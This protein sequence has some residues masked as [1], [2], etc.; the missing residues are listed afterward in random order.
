MAGIGNL[1][2][3][4]WQR[5]ERAAAQR[6]YVVQWQPQPLHRRA[7]RLL[8]ELELALAH[9]LLAMPQPFFIEIGANDGVA[10][11]PLYPFV[12]AG[13]LRGILLEPVPEVFA[14]LAATHAGNDAVRCVNAALAAEDGEADFFTVDMAGINFAKAQQ[15]SSFHRE[16]LLRQTDWVPDIARRIVATRV[17][18]V[19][20][21]TLQAMAREMGAPSIDVLH[22]D[23]EGFD[24]RVLEMMWDAGLSP[25]LVS[26]ERLHMDKA[27]IER[28]VARLVAAG[29]RVAM[30]DADVVAYRAPPWPAA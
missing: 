19:S 17:P 29:H 10:N 25:A 28:H 20:F 5:A 26:F 21:A 16:A 2:R 15:F 18:T 8:P 13:R 7:A 30:G 23:T 22:T 9:L 24:G 3:A 6:G 11:D 14:K 4:A 27:E 12:R 1:A